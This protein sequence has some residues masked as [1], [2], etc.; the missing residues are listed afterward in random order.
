MEDGVLSSASWLIWTEF[1]CKNIT[2]VKPIWIMHVLDKLSVEVVEW[3][4][5]RG[6]LSV[7]SL[8][9]NDLVA[10]FGH[11]FVLSKSSIAEF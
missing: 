5:A 7:C 10:C 2:D 4:E 11:E 9:I 3:V 8:H 1:F 6:K